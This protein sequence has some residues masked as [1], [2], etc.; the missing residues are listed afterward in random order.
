MPNLPRTT[1][2]AQAEAASIANPSRRKKGTQGGDFVVSEARV[3]ARSEVPP[4]TSTDQQGQHSQEYWEQAPV[5][6][7]SEVQDEHQSRARL[8]EARARIEKLTRELAQANHACSEMRE[9]SRQ[10]QAHRD[11]KLNEYEQDN[12][13]LLTENAD[14]AAQVETLTAQ[15][16][17]NGAAQVEAQAARIAI[18]EHDLAQAQAQADLNARIVQKDQEEHRAVLAENTNLRAALAEQ[19]DTPPARCPACEIKDQ[20][21]AHLEA[22]NEFNDRYIAEFQERERWIKRAA[23]SDEIEA[24]TKLVAMAMKDACRGK[25]D[26]YTAVY[27]EDIAKASGL[28]RQ[29]A[30][31]HMNAAVEWGMFGGYRVEEKATVPDARLGKREIKKKILHIAPTSLLDRPEDWK[32]GDGKQHGGSTRR[33]KRCGAEDTLRVVPHTVCLHCGAEDIFIPAD[34]QAA[35]DRARSLQPEDAQAAITEAMAIVAQVAPAAQV[36]EAA[37][38]QVDEPEISEVQ[39][40]H[41]SRARLEEA[42]ALFA[43]MQAHGC[44]LRI[45]PEDG[46][47]GIGCP[48]SWSDQQYQALE[49]KVLALAAEMRALVEEAAQ[50]SEVQDEHDCQPAQEAAPAEQVEPAAPATPASIIEAFGAEHGYKPAILTNGY[51]IPGGVVGWRGFI[52]YQDRQHAQACED[53][54][55]GKVVFR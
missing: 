50:V 24:A 46:A 43:K 10:I 49:G 42:R 33:C 39:D 14:L 9:F 51:H 47:F 1:N 12:R 7:I 17:E 35:L 20:R 54:Q 52:K 45:R 15:L 34:A 21:I 44:S 40:E 26:G 16:E 30:G 27:T 55:A 2:T 3:K 19:E 22:L 23:A 6:E 4:E 25:Q 11:K 53:I 5:D 31:R 28:N 8:E 13:R 37:P 36:E 38:A 41:Q 29:A 48:E 32:R 18:L